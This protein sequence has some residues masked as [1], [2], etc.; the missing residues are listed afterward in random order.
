MTV[1][2][3]TIAEAVRKH[4]VLQEAL[5][6]P[7]R[8]EY[9]NSSHTRRPQRWHHYSLRGS[10]YTKARQILS[11]HNY[12]LDNM[13][14]HPGPL[15]PAPPS[16]LFEPP[17]VDNIP[18][19]P[20]LDKVNP[21]HGIVFF[22]AG[23]CGKTSLVRSVAAAASGE[24]PKSTEAQASGVDTFYELPAQAKIDV[25]GSFKKDIPL[26]LTDTPPLESG[27]MAA[28]LTAKSQSHHE[29]ERVE[30]HLFGAVFE[31]KGACS[32]SEEYYEEFTSRYLSKFCHFLG[33]ADPSLVKYAVA[34]ATVFDAPA[35]PTRRAFMASHDG[36]PEDVPRT[37]Q[38]TLAK[39]RGLQ[40]GNVYIRSQ[41]L[42]LLQAT[43]VDSYVQDNFHGGCLAIPPTYRVE[44]HI[45]L[46][47]HHQRPW[48]K[49]S[50]RPGTGNALD[51]CFHHFRS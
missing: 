18:E 51:Q 6:P 1:A 11:E 5:D 37:F 31:G 45:G 2:A 29:A 25:F 21:S 43:Q 49:V 7:N 13:A 16:S 10:D 39:E 12:V 17:T 19:P 32:A 38:S 42:R 47:S 15:R 4:E 27:A 23:Q 41:L 46:R 24:Y 40:P 30:E 26:V 8:R 36:P 33:T 3:T 9:P 34:N 35:W 44:E 22:G 48:S 28:S 50:E 20:V 14:K